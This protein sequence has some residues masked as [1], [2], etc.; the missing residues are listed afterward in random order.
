LAES[1]LFLRP[2]RS[3]SGQI[4]PVDVDVF[5]RTALGTRPVEN[6]PVRITTAVFGVERFGAV[7]VIAGA[8]VDVPGCLHRPTSVLAVGRIIV[9]SAPPPP[10]CRRVCYPC[11]RHHRRPSMIP[12]GTLNLSGTVCAPW[13][14][15]LVAV[16]GCGAVKA[17]LTRV[18]TL[19]WK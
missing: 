8:A 4:I 1:L 2:S 5:L 11:W 14:P 10:S 16:G 17:R 15:W 3:G 9:W 6:R 7:Q 19:S 13:R 12:L 18:D